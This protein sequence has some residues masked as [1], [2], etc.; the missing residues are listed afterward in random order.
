VAALADR[1]EV[2]TWDRRGHSRSESTAGPGSRAQDAADLAALIDH[3]GGGAVHVAGNSYG[4][5]VTLTLVST[6]PDLVASAAVH[7]PPALALLDGATDPE[8]AALLASLDTALGEVG[9]LIE[10]G[11]HRAAAERFVDEVALGRGSWAMLPDASRAVF[12]ANAPTFLDELRDPTSSSVDAAA[13]A[14]TTVPLL[15]SIG[16]ESPSCFPA[17]IAELALLVPE[18]RVATIAGGH[19]PHATN[20]DQWVATL[21]AFHD[22]VAA[23]GR[24]A[25]R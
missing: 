5:I 4:S 13:L 1:Y 24:G 12:E 6:R 9:A 11:D 21:V 22:A 10:E 25:T 14:A 20:P 23:A 17:V 15:F 19:I 7:E 8:L 16:R 18:A 2:V 3:L